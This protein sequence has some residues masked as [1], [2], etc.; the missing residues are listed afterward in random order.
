[1][2][3]DASWWRVLVGGLLALAFALVGGDLAVQAMRR[4]GSF[5]RVEEGLDPD[6]LKQARSIGHVERTL[7]LASLIVGQH[8]FVGVW[9]TLKIVGSAEW[10]LLR[11]EAVTD[12][13]K[14]RAVFQRF[15]ILSGVSLAYAAG[16]WGIFLTFV[17]HDLI[18][19]A[20]AGALLGLSFVLLW[21]LEDWKWGRPA[22][23]FDLS[24]GFLRCVRGVVGSGEQVRISPERVVA[25]AQVI[26]ET[27]SLALSVGVRRPKRGSC[28]TTC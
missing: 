9:L 5:G 28:W 27:D 17:R 4:T 22:R 16:G 24:H 14:R 12:A 21:Q 3:L 19:A 25:Q 18:D 1:M 11:Q 10:P 2:M 13:L 23:R 20:P 8:V 7:Y 15:L 6:I 26:K